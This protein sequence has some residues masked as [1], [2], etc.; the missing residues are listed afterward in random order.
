MF[1]T[2]FQLTIFRG[3]LCSHRFGF[4]KSSVGR[5]SN[6][7]RKKFRLFSLILGF[8][9]FL[10]VGI[11][12][13]VTEPGAT[14]ILWDTYGVPH[15]YGKDTRSLF[16]AFGWAQMQSHGNL[17]LRLYG[18]AR[19]RAAE[20]WGEDYL[21]S[22]RWVRTMGVSGRARQ[23]YEA[24]SPTFRS[25]LD[26]FAAG[27]NAYVREHADRIDDEVEVV[28]P[29]DAVDLLAHTQ[30]LIHFTFMVDSERVAEINSDSKEQEQAMGS[31]AWAIAPA[32]SASGNA[33]L[34]AN[35]H[36]PWSDLFLWYEAQLTAPD[37][38]A[39]GATLVGIPV[40]TIA[41]NDHLGWTH[42]VN[43]HDGWDA[44]KLTLADKGYRWD[45]G[46]RS[47]ETEEQILQVKQDDAP[48]RQEPLV[49][50]H[51]IHGPVIAQSGDKAIALRVVGL[52][53]PGVLEQWWDMARAKN[54]AEFE[55]GLKR[56]QLP[57]FTVMYADRDGHIMHLFNG[58]LPVRSK[59]NF[60]DWE[61]LIPGD[62]STTLWTKM[63]SYGDLPRV[64]DP[65]SGWL[66]NAND[67]PW[68]TTFPLAL[69]PND[70]P[71]YM[72]PHDPTWFWF[73]QQRSARMLAE[74]QQISFEEMV[75]YKHST[76]MELADRL[77]D[78]LIPAARQQGN[79]LARR[80]ADV[81]DA[82]DHQA[83]ADSRGAVLFASWAEAVDTDRL[84]AAPWNQNSPVTT[85]DG[86]K[87]PP[88]AVAALEDAAAK[89]EATYGTLDVSWGQ[90]FRLHAGDLD[91]PANG[92]PGELGI[93]RVLDFAPSEN[94]RF[95]SIQ[96]D[97]YVAA[98]EF[99]NPVRAMVLTSYGNATQPGSPHSEDQLDLF[100]RK[101]LRP[102]WRTCEEIEAHLASR[103]KF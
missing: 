53:Q 103:Q 34:L 102:V 83:N 10:L 78:D 13:Q 46:V 47:F 43:T 27:I 45:G 81:L 80:A 21:E 79:E 4:P 100:A 92:G 94:G 36:L 56:L 41:F 67:P 2:Q 25:N 93:F 37:I 7:K 75:K 30:R 71:P 77:L 64:L 8:V 38:N 63:H 57:M 86:L 68:T 85:P 15:I 55:A 87:D 74:D 32:R 52:N 90:V 26:A 40:L 33:M 16:H 1:L 50:R 17:I 49:V 19:G 69:D 44:Y 62:T 96:G 82:W 24:Q 54:L 98:I 14:E 51:S 84:F 3:H 22:D 97:S 60:A 76:R 42:T 89:V 95:Q 66:Q 11:L 91:L 59:G 6:S 101:E 48:L 23:W 5:H 28:L 70:Y 61:G 58:Q 35:P 20:Y 65:V 73:R 88:V 99:S 18:Q 31:N 72:A 29:V 39:Y 9:L 12:S